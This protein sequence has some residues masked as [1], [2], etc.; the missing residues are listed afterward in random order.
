MASAVLTLPSGESHTLYS[1]SPSETSEII[2][3][4][5]AMQ[6]EVNAALT[7]AIEESGDADAQAAPAEDDDDD[8]DDEEP[9][10][11]DE[12]E[13]AAVAETPGC[14]GGNSEPN[15]KRRKVT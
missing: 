10:A 2:A 14:N 15:A 6:A 11:E 13:G 7:K 5:R 1:S 9:A 12:S 8:E 4:T 3:A